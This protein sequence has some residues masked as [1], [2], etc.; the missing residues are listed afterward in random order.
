MGRDEARTGV[1]DGGPGHPSLG[2]GRHYVFYR[3][4][5]TTT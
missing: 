5:S 4:K 3:D 2:G 1:V